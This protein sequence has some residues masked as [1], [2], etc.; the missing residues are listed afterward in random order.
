MNKK[1]SVFMFFIILISSTVYAKFIPVDISRAVNMDFKDKI[2]GDK[3]GGWTDQGANDLRK[4]PVGKQTFYGIP[5]NIMDPSEN[6][7]KSCIVLFGGER[8]YFPMDA[9]F[10]IEQKAKSIY[11]LH[12]VAWSASPPVFSYE[13][14]Y[15]DGESFEKMIYIGKETSTFWDPK[16]TPA[17]KV[18]WSGD[19]PVHSPVGVSIYGL[20]N[21][22]PDKV[23]KGIK[24]HSQGTAAVPVVIAVTISDEP[25]LEIFRERKIEKREYISP[26]TGKW[27]VLKLS[28]DPLKDNSVFFMVTD[29]PAGR[30]GFLQVKNGKFVFADGTQIKFNGVTLSKYAIPPTKTDAQVLAKRLAKFGFNL[31]RFHALIA[32]LQDNSFGSIDKEK[33]DKMDYFISQLKKNGIYVLFD[34]IFAVKWTADNKVE[35]Y[36]KLNEMSLNSTYIMWDSKT[37]SILKKFI[38]DLLT[39]TNPY[40]KKAYKDEPSLVLSA[41]LNEQSTFFFSPDIY[42]D[43]YQKL[44]RDKWNLWL[45]SKYKTEKNLL[46]LWKVNGE[47]SPLE[48][49]ENLNKKSIEL[50]N[51]WS[52]LLNP[53][54]YQIKRAKDQTKFL[55]EI[56]HSFFLE[57]KNLINKEIG[58]KVLV[59]GSPWQGAKKLNWIDLYSNAE[60]LDYIDKHKYYDHP[61]NGWTLN[62]INFKNISFLKSKERFEWLYNLAMTRVKSMPF[63]ISEWNFAIPN[64]YN[65]E[66]PIV[67]GSISALQDWDALEIFAWDG[68]DW[69]S[70]WDDAFNINANPTEV[71]QMPVLYNMFVRGDVKP[72]DI[73]MK[74]VLTF[75]NVINVKHKYIDIDKKAVV[76]GKLVTEFGNKA[77]K[78][79]ENFSSYIDNERKIIKSGTQEIWW[80][81]EKGLYKVNAPKTQ[82]A[83]GFLN[84]VNVHCDDVLIKV[85]T[86]FCSLFLT[87]L[88]NKPL[89][90]SKHIL[91]TSVGRIRN[92]GAEYEMDKDNYMKLKS[93]GSAPFI[94]EPVKAR[95]QLKN[96]A[97]KI[98]VYPVDENGFRIDGREIKVFNEGGDFKFMINDIIPYYE[99]VVE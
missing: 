73:I 31:V 51:V 96:N 6:S 44:L 79:D 7:G 30:H 28:P 40:T 76:I 61:K 85:D 29:K 63:T 43:Y 74:R 18:A 65:L 92:K 72:G 53:K 10:L 38:K 60:G 56:Q 8:P 2:E 25:L 45:L 47:K 12:T 13:I 69:M 15:E 35:D 84:K 1:V 77:D 17:S 80:Q 33:L 23:I 32:K 82:G 97:K 99:V 48:E 37:K 59:C 26:D 14:V 46:N 62:T 50:Y 41:I 64:E 42:P 75:D 94:A 67:M 16:D 98:K 57:M 22:H 5:F 3:K 66:A 95:I 87:S 88:D 9:K 86:D 54:P 71:F 70:S 68:S 27:K 91:I 78:I 58:A 49:N 39:H 20:A 89:K 21:P 4:F 55:Y 34:F 83:V 81:Y 36:K 11:F 19:N 90:E 52:E 93:L 24:I